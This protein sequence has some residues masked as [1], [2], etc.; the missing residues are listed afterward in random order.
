MMVDPLARLAASS[1]MIST[2]VDTTTTVELKLESTI[3]ADLGGASGGQPPPTP[4]F[5]LPQ[6]YV[7]GAVAVGLVLA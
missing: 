1:T 7:A 4:W 6:W 5:G 3:V 2:L